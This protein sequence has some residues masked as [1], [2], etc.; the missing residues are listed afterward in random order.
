MATFQAHIRRNDIVL[1]CAGREAEG[2]KTGKVLQVMPGKAMAIVEGLNYIHKCLRKSQDHPKGGIIKKEGPIAIS[3][4]MLY[5]P[6]CK[7]GVRV[8]RVREESG[9]ASRKCKACG[10]SFDG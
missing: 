9:K 2:Q 5:C 3:N 1:V 6:H 8:A 4:L 10:H 7:D